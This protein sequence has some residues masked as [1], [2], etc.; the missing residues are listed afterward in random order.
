M[1]SILLLGANSDIGK[2]L[3]VQYSKNGYT[4]LLAGRRKERLESLKADLSIRNQV[5]SETFEFDALD[6]SS[7]ES[8]Y[9]SLG[10]TPEIS[11]CIFGYLGDQ[12]KAEIDWEEANRVISTNY[13]GAIS[14]LNIIVEDYKRLGQG[15]IV[16]IS[17]VA[18]DRGR[19]SNYIYGSA[20]AGFTA[21]LSGL[22][23]KMTQFGVHVMTVK[24]GF[25]NTRMTEDLKLP[26]PITAQPENVANAIFKG[27]KKKKNV[28]YV[29][30]M[31]KWIMLI[32]RSIPE[33]IFKKMKL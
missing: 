28:I 19:S 21:Y 29:L 18:G 33:S 15:T 31:W 27:A 32:I 25:V 11:V 2:A 24:P 23:N 16:G 12:D 13:T 4:I 6:Y 10:S 14:I 20:K 7:H 5:N 3:A 8:F 22:R 1:K 17:S 9:K 30:W 26:G